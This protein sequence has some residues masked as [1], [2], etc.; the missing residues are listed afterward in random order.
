M[1]VAVGLD[2]FLLFAASFR[3]L[4]EST[5]DSYYSLFNVP[6]VL[7]QNYDNIE[8][9]LTESPD[10]PVAI[11]TDLEDQLI[12][13]QYARKL[14]KSDAAPDSHNAEFIQTYLKKLQRTPG[15]ESLTEVYG[16]L[17][18]VTHPG[19]TSV[20]MWIESHNELEM[21]FTDKQERALIWSLANQNESIITILLMASMNLPGM[22][23]AVLNH[24]S[25]PE[26]HT[27]G[28]K[29]Y[30]FDS[31]PE[32]RNISP[33]LKGKHAKVPTAK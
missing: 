4:L 14:R 17:C 12:H 22:S 5:A 26:L 7:A 6:R 15:L 19:A 23:L 2:N 33:L 8:G 27:P 29:K 3:G 21:S 10:L 11:S 32:W 28:L 20:W 13:F 16:Y 30:S 18:D 24:F 31:I 9:N 1:K 25:Y